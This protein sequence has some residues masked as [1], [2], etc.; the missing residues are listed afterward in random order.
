[1][2]ELTEKCDYLCLQV[3][4][5]QNPFRNLF[6]RTIQSVFS[7][8]S[9][10]IVLSLFLGEESGIPPGIPPDFPNSH[11]SRHDVCSNPAPMREPLYAAPRDQKEGSAPWRAQT[12]IAS[13]RRSYFTMWKERMRG[14]G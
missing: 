14:M 13:M 4:E 8:I 11:Y 3:L 9:C 2:Y 6:R 10:V 1:M 7:Q 5:I 12:R